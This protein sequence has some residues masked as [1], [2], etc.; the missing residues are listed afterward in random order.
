FTRLGAWFRVTSPAVV[1]GMLAGI[2]ILI[3]LSQLHVML[4]AKP[5]ASGLSNLLAFPGAAL[6]AASQWNGSGSGAQA[7]LIGLL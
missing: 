3:V 5:A 7:A 1:Y 2:G 4:D 6:T